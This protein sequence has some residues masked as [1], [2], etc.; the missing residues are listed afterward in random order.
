M[1]FYFFIFENTVVKISK[2]IFSPSLSLSN[3]KNIQSIFSAN[4]YNYF[5]VYPLSQSYLIVSASNKVK[6]SV[7]SQLENFFGKSR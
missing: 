7:F 4:F 6:G 1:K 5:L 2:D 3:H